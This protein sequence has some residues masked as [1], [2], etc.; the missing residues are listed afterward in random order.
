M[1]NIDDIFGRISSN[2]DNTAPDYTSLTGN[3][4]INNG[5]FLEDLRTYYGSKGKSF[6]STSD[7]LDD[8]YTDRRWKD[9]NFLSAGLDMAEYNNC[10]L[11][12]SPSPRD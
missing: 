9:S 4:L 10:L 6:S 2:Q 3:E 11:Y 8:W 12:T 1:S 5:S 7:M